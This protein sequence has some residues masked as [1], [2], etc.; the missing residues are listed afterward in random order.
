MKAPS[1]IVAAALLGTLLL[2]PAIIKRVGL[3]E[4]D[5][6]KEPQAGPVAGWLRGESRH[7]AESHANKTNASKKQTITIGEF[8]VDKI[9]FFSK[10]VKP[11]RLQPFYMMPFFFALK[12]MFTLLAFG[13]SL[14]FKK[15]VPDD[16]LFGTLKS[17]AGGVASLA[18]IAMA[19]NGYRTDYIVATSYF[20]QIEGF[21]MKCGVFLVVWV[22]SS[23][24]AATKAIWNSILLDNPG[25]LLELEPRYPALVKVPLSP[26]G[27]NW[28]SP[29]KWTYAMILLPY[30]LPSYVY[31]ASSGMVLCC[32]C[33]CINKCAVC[34]GSLTA[35]CCLVVS[36]FGVILTLG[37]YG[38]AKE[39]LHYW[40]S[41]YWPLFYATLI[42]VWA[43][44]IA[45]RLFGAIY[46]CLI[47]A[48]VNSQAEAQAADAEA[49]GQAL[50]SPDVSN[51]GKTM[52]KQFQGPPLVAK[53]DKL[54]LKALNAEKLKVDFYNVDVP[55]VIDETELEDTKIMIFM[56]TYKSMA[57]IIVEQMTVIFLVRALCATDY[58]GYVGAMLRT[59]SERTWKKYF[60]HMGKLAEANVTEAMN[61]IWSI[62]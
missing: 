4:P 28:L 13:F 59:C 57:T 47:C 34:W 46:G 38:Y 29:L 2:A 35:S 32:W 61:Y 39:C 56:A 14:S 50:L 60:A 21:W 7:L 23:N 24:Y 16:G 11:D 8:D 41:L 19:L 37:L 54:K 44:G 5:K 62:V 9:D 52:E 26:F 3:A 27:A 15:S 18:F 30:F 6:S 10:I 40:W 33:C 31:Q 58:D 43:L 12:L 51:L 42:Q 1:A 48:S 20:S 49:Q 22:T 25:N 17:G 53:D 45:P 36:L 55:G